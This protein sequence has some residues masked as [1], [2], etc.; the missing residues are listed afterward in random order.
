[1]ERRDYAVPL[2]N[3]STT[4]L[5]YLLPFYPI[6]R[7]PY[8]HKTLHLYPHPLFFCLP[9]PLLKFVVAILSHLLI[10]ASVLLFTYS[11]NLSL[12]FLILSATEAIPTLSYIT[13]FLIISL[14]VVHTSIRSSL[15]PLLSSSKCVHS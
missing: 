8:L 9:L 5:N 6:R 15:S 3:R 7:P 14:L 10:G 2:P 4:S 11:N 1:M 13:L 12:G